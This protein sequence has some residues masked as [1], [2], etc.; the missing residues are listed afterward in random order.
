MRWIG[1]LAA[2]LM[3]WTPGLDA[4]EREVE[5]A[6]EATL[7]ALSEGRYEDFLS[8]F[9]PSARGFFL[10]GGS[11]LST[12]FSA[13]QL[14]LAAQAGAGVDVELDDLDSAVHGDAA[15]SVAYLEGSVTLPGGIVVEGVWRYSETRVLVDGAWKVVQFHMSE[16]SGMEGGART[17][18]R[19]PTPGSRA[20]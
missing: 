8:H 12:G 2:A 20:R 14:N 11:L 5:D 1:A 10:D 17:A 13:Q 7:E 9:L 6:V 15:V 18:S 16:M 3:I 4:Q 19:T